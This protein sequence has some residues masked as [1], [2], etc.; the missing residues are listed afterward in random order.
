MF[1]RPVGALL[2]SLPLLAVIFFSTCRLSAELVG[3]TL[4]LDYG[5]GHP[6]DN[7][8]ANFMY[9]VPLISP[10]RVAVFTN[11]GNTQYARVTSFRCRT[12]GA[13]FHAVCEFDFT[14]D[15]I[16]RSVFDHAF[17]IR[18]REKELN[19]GKPLAHQLAAINVQGA[20][21]GSMEID[22]TFNNGQ[23]A[24]TE[25]QLRFY[26]RGHP[27]PVSVNLQDIV[28]R[29]GEIHYENEMVARVNTLTFHQKSPP[30]MEVTLASVKKKDAANSLWQ[31]FVGGIKGVTANL[32][33]P[34]LNITPGGEQTMMDFGAALA[35]QKP[36][37][38]FPIATRLKTNWVAASLP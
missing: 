15:G 22:G 32:L 2:R 10:E 27:S 19:A 8:L 34:P 20:G 33:L 38:T 1:F 16:Q 26:S 23:P 21:S 35:A 14:G 30:K 37:F 31:N 29:N 3:P 28:L 17:V 25:M 6:L 4:K 36:A 9:F 7:P 11:A 24:V 12:N 13:A 5:R 18:R